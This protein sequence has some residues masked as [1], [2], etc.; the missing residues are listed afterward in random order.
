M[1]MLK[2]G[3]SKINLKCICAHKHAHACSG[4]VPACVRARVC[5][6]VC[7]CLCVCVSVCDCEC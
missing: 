3:Y 1:Y 6:S 7:V 5:I 2:P 4:Y